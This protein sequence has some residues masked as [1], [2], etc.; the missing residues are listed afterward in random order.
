[1]TLWVHGFNATVLKHQLSRR[2]VGRGWLGG[3]IDPASQ[4]HW[5]EGGSP[6]V[7]G[8]SLFDWVLQI[9]LKTNTAMRYIEPIV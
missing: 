2:F 9:C 8:V 7:S 1:M 4:T 5:Q 3:G 6:R